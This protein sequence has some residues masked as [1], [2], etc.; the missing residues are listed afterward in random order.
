MKCKN[1]K[2]FS[3]IMSGEPPTYDES[4]CHYEIIQHDVVDNYWCRHFEAIKENSNI[5][6]NNYL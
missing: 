3:A 5:V 2:W 6:K 1:C 4:V